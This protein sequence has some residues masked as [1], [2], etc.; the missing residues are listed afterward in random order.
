MLEIEYEFREKDLIHFN[1][2]QFQHSPEIQR[3]FRQNRLIVPGIII[4]VGLFYWAYYGDKVSSLYVILLGL[5]WALISP[6]V[7]RWDLRRQVLVNYSDKEKLAM[8]G[9]YKL[10]IEPKALVEKSPSGKHKMEWKDLLRVEQDEQ[11]A[12]IY[13]DVGA[14]L[15]IPRETVSKGNL[16]E[17]AKQAGDLIDRLG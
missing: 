7:L 9:T 5:S 13:V 8:F 15:I 10:T 1:E 14:A 6:L 2:K 3:N 12:Y 4:I 16:D 11:Y 17:F